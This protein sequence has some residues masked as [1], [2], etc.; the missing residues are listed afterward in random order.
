MQL[1]ETLV[2]PILQNIESHLTDLPG[3]H[4]PTVPIVLNVF[5]LADGNIISS[6]NSSIVGILGLVYPHH[7]KSKVKNAILFT[8][9]NLDSIYIVRRSH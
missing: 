3:H 8:R 5:P 4:F 9:I 1:L 2:F 6:I 7:L